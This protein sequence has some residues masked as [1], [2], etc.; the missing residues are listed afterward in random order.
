MFCIG[1]LSASFDISVV[2]FKFVTQLSKCGFLHRIYWLTAG[3]RIALQQ[4]SSTIHK[5]LKI[6]HLKNYSKYY[7]YTTRLLSFKYIILYIRT[8]LG[9]S[10]LK[11]NLYYSTLLKSLQR[12]YNPH[13]T[14]ILT[15][16]FR[17]FNFH[18]NFFR[19]WIF[20]VSSPVEE[21][22]RYFLRGDLT[23]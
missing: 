1:S 10:R 23:D 3:Q 5:P 4:D 9:F 2:R 11:P 12:T 20:L 8:A 17:A 6:L 22:K 21:N 18:A 13:Q 15:T 16:T 14:D 7:N 19:F